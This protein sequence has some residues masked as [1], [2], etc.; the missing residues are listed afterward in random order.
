MRSLCAVP[1]HPVP[2]Q[3][4]GQK[5]IELETAAQMLEVVL[6]GGRFVQPFCTFLVEQGEYKKIN[7]DQ[8][9]K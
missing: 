5:I 7:A 1:A 9:A 8:W 6:P 2:L 4:P 3:E